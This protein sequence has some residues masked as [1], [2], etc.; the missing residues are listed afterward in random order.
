MSDPRAVLSRTGPSPAATVAYGQAP[1]QVADLW[2][3]AAPDR[4]SLVVFVHGGYW[5]PEYDRLH[6]WSLAADLA[7]RGHLVASVEYRRGGES[8]GGWPGTFDDVAGAV[9]KLPDLAA[10]RYGAGPRDRRLVLVGHS[11]GGQLALWVAARHRLPATSPWHRPRDAAPEG[12]LAL[13][14]VCDLGEAYRRD[15]DDGA[16]IAFLG[17][18]PADLPDRYA[19]ADPRS[20]LPYGVPTV[21]LHGRLDQQVPIALSRGYVA[22]ARAAGDPVTLVELPDAE[23]FALIDPESAAWPHVVETVNGIT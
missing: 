13:A 6:T 8:G 19:L 2:F 5:R 14:P 4:G 23:H 9:D 22:A 18:G 16:V 15:L 20:L 17:G 12:V 21:V 10:A 7:A 11:A 1:D 3:P